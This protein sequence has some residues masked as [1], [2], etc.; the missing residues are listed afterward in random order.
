MDQELHQIRQR[1]LEMGGIVEEM[2]GSAMASLVER[3]SELARRV[4]ERDREVDRLEKSI[5]ETC[6]TVMAT[7]QPTA[8]DLRFLVV[9]MKIVNDLERMGDSAKNIAQSALVVNLEP[10]L[11]PYIDLP[12]MAQLTREMVHDCLDAFV[13]RDSRLAREVWQRDD[14]IDALYHQLFRELLTYMI[15][16]PKTASIALHLLLIALNLERVADHA[17]NICEDVI[18]FVDGADIRHQATHYEP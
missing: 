12:H 7:R 13:Q 1:L 9:S 17:T 15:E 3:D 8:S 16:Q 14:T 5:D 6:V 4:V 11:K 2:V 18:Y 10:Q